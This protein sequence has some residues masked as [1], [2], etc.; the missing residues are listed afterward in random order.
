MT[1]KTIPELEAIRSLL[2]RTPATPKG[3]RLPAE[4]QEVVAECLREGLSISATARATGTTRDQV[5]TVKYAMAGVT[6]RQV[7]T[8][9]R[10]LRARP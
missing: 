6:L 2:E 7:R 9:K 3:S 8:L 10:Q 1:N 5:R 4:V